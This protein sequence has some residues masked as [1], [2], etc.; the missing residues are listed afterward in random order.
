MEGTVKWYS[1]MKSYGFI[2][3][4]DGKDVFVHRNA[5]PEGTILRE[6][7]SVEFDIEQTPKGPQA[8]NVKKK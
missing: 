4:E 6:G 5:L 8:I 2:Q 7:D 3:V 1:D